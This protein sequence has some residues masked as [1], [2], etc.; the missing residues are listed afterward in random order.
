MKI[1]KGTTV[2]HPYYIYLDF[3]FQE[4]YS[5]VLQQFISIGRDMGGTIILDCGSNL[6]F[7]VYR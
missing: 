3:I 1:A 2:T 6:D 4:S 5:S 7:I